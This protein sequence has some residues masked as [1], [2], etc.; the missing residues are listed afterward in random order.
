MVIAKP[1]VVGGNGITK[2]EIIASAAATMTSPTVIKDSGAIQADALNDNY[3]LECIA[4]EVQNELPGARYVAARIT[5]A[6]A[7]DEATVTYIADPVFPRSGLTPAD[8]IS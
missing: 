2:L 3:K 4:E 7:T 1:N 5:M 6:T 8:S